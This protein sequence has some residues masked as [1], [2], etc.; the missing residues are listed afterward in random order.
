LRETDPVQPLTPS[1]AATLAGEQD[2]VVFTYT[3]ALETVRLRYFYVYGPR[4][5]DGARD[6]EI[7]TI[8]RD[9]VAGRCPVIHGDGAEAHDLIY[10]DDVVYA[11]LFAAE[12]PRVTGKV[13]NVGRGRATTA[14]DV[15]V[16]VNALLGTD[17]N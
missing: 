8:I 2:C 15:V 11:N 10:V 12:A 1:A 9:M 17:L 5:A 3:Y 7:M 13:Y 16:Q 6:T 14:L 4:Q